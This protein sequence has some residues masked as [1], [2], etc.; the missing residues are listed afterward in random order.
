MPL[1]ES[2][3]VSI[4]FQM[5]FSAYYFAVTWIFIFFKDALQGSRNSSFLVCTYLLPEN[6]TLIPGNWCRV[7]HCQSMDPWLFSAIGHQ[8]YKLPCSFVM[9]RWVYFMLEARTPLGFFSP[10]PLGEGLFY[11]LAP[12]DHLSFVIVL[13]YFHYK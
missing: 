3:T 9:V 8:P 12:L 4:H 6:T 1:L 5:N 7:A 13:Q 11:L 2:Y 10:S